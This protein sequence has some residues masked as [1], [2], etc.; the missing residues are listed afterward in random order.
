M[1]K[2]P[3]ISVVIVT[4]QSGNHIT[5]CLRSLLNE[6][7]NTD[8]KIIIIDNNSLDET[9]QRLDEL[10]E[11]DAVHLIF[12][13]K[14]LGFTKALN[15]GLGKVQGDFILILN[16]D[17]VLQPGCLGALLR[18]L[19]EKPQVGVVAPQLLHEDSSVQP[20]CRRFPKLRDVVFNLTGLSALFNSSRLFNGWKMGD[21]GHDSQRSV[22]QPQ[23]AFLLLRKKILP[24]VGLWDESFPM[25]FSDVDW[26]KRVKEHGVDILFEPAAKAVHRKGASIAKLRSRMIWSSHRSF[27]RYFKK[28]R[29]GI[30]FLTEI[31]GAV[32]IL[33]AVVRIAGTLLVRIVAKVK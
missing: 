8:Y 4:Y 19:G 3:K 13:E 20:S 32:L 17:I 7:K 22:E 23:G 25:F 18:S 29:Q 16:P 2:R 14:N 10:K 31:L 28:H 30:G 11:N 26:C 9:R 5:A 6:L 27:Y 15:Q 33:S 1:T 21:F 12:N 24:E